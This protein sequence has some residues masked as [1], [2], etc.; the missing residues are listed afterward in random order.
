MLAGAFSLADERLLPQ[1]TDK[2]ATN[3]Y[4]PATTTISAK[5]RNVISSVSNFCVNLT[6]TTLA[7]PV[8]LALPLRK[9]DV[10]PVQLEQV[11]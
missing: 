1:Q 8:K 4:R 10:L 3:E 9:R 5:C 2:P 6:F 11:V 7:G